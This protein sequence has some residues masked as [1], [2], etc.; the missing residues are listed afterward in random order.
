MSKMTEQQLEALISAQDFKVVNRVHSD[1]MNA[2]FDYYA[3]NHSEE[4]NI[5]NRCALAKKSVSNF[6]QEYNNKLSR[7]NTYHNSLENQLS[8]LKNASTMIAQYCAKVIVEQG[9]NI[10]WYS[11]DFNYLFFYEATQQGKVDWRAPYLS[12]S[13]SSDCQRRMINFL[14][15]NEQKETFTAFTKLMNTL[16]VK[17]EIFFRNWTKLASRKNEKKLLSTQEPF[18]FIKQYRESDLGKSYIFKVEALALFD[19]KKTAPIIQQ[20]FNEQQ[21][22]L[23]LQDKIANI[24]TKLGIEQE[25][26]KVDILLQSLQEEHIV[27][28]KI[29]SKEALMKKGKISKTQLE[30][31][32]EL[33]RYF[34]NCSQNQHASK[35]EYEENVSFYIA[36]KSYSVSAFKITLTNRYRYNHETSLKALEDILKIYTGIYLTEHF[37]NLVNQ[38]I[39]SMMTKDALYE[40]FKKIM[41]S[42]ALREKLNTENAS[43][44]G[45]P[46]RKI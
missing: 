33:M 45:T 3:L 38:D 12:Y 20:I 39:S 2:F 44:S 13:F 19:K 27:D 5:H 34:I 15:N 18:D 1:T 28:Y 22:N 10:D 4:H 9:L 40:D 30:K 41:Q 6:I 25:V 24:L 35:V 17:S 43:S 11:D 23:I 7:S 21:G 31:Y 16:Q 32:F 36:E 14:I 42:V 46:K 26:D 8:M 37:P 29:L